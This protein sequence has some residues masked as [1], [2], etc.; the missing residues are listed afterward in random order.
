MSE[1][2]ELVE[3]FSVRKDAIESVRRNDDGTLLIRTSDNEY[4]VN[5]DYKL[6]ILELD[7]K[8]RIQEEE[9]KYLKQYHGG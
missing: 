8:M 5:G 4:T 7:E 2:I 1:F 3:G 6:V 9:D